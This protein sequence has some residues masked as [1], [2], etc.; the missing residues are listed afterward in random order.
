MNPLNKCL[1]ICVHFVLTPI[2]KI[3]LFSIVK[4]VTSVLASTMSLANADF[5]IGIDKSSSLLASCANL[6]ASIIK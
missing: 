6:R 2:V 3:I 5:N 1:A 4:G